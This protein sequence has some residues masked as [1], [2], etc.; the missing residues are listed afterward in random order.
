MEKRLLELLALAFQDELSGN[1]RKELEV[2]FQ[3][4]PEYQVLAKKLQFSY[5]HIDEL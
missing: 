3:K 1:E 4:F 2:L 5:E